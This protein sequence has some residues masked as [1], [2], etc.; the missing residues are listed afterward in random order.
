MA[1]T[2]LKKTSRTFSRRS[3][4]VLSRPCTTGKLIQNQTKR[5]PELSEKGR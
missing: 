2:I 4:F 3:F 5:N 1:K